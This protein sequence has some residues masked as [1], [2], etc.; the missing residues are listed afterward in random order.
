MDFA[1]RH[2][3][4]GAQSFFLTFCVGIKWNLQGYEEY[5]GIIW[6]A[7]CL[8]SSV[9]QTKCPRRSAISGIVLRQGQNDRENPHTFSKI[10]LFCSARGM[11]ASFVRRDRR[12][13]SFSVI[14]GILRRFAPQKDIIRCLEGYERRAAATDLLQPFK[15]CRNRGSSSPR[16]CFCIRRGDHKHS[17]VQSCCLTRYYSTDKCMQ[18]QLRLCEFYILNTLLTLHIVFFA[19]LCRNIYYI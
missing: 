17:L 8:Y 11:R 2:R 18:C 16:H 5:F 12:D 3:S 1:R 13:P 15:C 19:V 10:S 6:S 4:S 9:Y 14:A 7:D